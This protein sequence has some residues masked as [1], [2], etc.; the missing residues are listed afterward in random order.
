[1]ILIF[2]LTIILQYNLIVAKLEFKFKVETK[3]RTP[4]TDFGRLGVLSISKL[5]KTM[6]CFFTIKNAISNFLPKPY[7]QI[8]QNEV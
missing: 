6:Q 7:C 1:M 2:M 8:L 3:T 4:K 5:L